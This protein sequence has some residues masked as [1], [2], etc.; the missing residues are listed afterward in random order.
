MQQYTIF[1]NATPITKPIS[2]KGKTAIYSTHVRPK[3]TSIS[4]FV[5]IEYRVS[6]TVTS[7]VP[8]V[9]VITTRLEKLDVNPPNMYDSQNVNINK[10]I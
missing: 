3:N 1:A 10:R 9:A 8:S 6:A 7:A 4:V 5:V 2:I